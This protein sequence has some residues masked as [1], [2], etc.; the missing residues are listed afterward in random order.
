MQLNNE[1]LASFI[2]RYRVFTASIHEERVSAFA[3]GFTKFAAGFKPIR[4][5]WLADQKE[6]APEF[7]IFEITKVETDEIWHSRFLAGLFDVRGKHGQRDLFVNGFTDLLQKK[8]ADI[9]DGITPY[10]V[11]VEKRVDSAD[12]GQIDIV[13]EFKGISNFAVI[14]ENKIGAGDQP[15]QLFRYY[16]NAKIIYDDFLLVYL[17]PKGKEPSENSI[18]KE[19]RQHLNKKNK[20]ILLSYNEDISDWLGKLTE[21]IDPV[22]LKETINM[23]IRTV[24]RL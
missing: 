9:P 2:D 24:K 5:S 13:I 8:G 15:R 19:T 14:I 21:E 1:Q 6:N 4:E 10:T 22:H 7:N 16:E 18:D 12:R 23:Y 11:K 3:E 20:L 17:S